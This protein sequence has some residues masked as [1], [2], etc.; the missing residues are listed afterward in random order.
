MFVAEPITKPE[1]TKP[2][3]DL[4]VPPDDAKPKHSDPPVYDTTQADLYR[5]EFGLR[6]F[7]LFTSILL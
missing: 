2:S 6:L 3:I 4:A 5:G 7:T 1:T